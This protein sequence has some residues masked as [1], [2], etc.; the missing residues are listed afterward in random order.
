[1]HG[2]YGFAS[3]FQEAQKMALGKA[4]A[5]LSVRIYRILQVSALYRESERCGEAER[6][7]GKAS[8]VEWK[9]EINDFPFAVR[10]LEH[11]R[12]LQ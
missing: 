9:E 1:M 3:A 8:L 11:C 10:I 2:A 6:E 4:F 7:G 12:I 5:G